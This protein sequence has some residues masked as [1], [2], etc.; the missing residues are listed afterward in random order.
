MLSGSGLVGI[1]QSPCHKIKQNG[2]MKLYSLHNLAGYTSLEP[3]PV[4][5][6]LSLAKRTW[7]K[8]GEENQEILRTIQRS[9]EKH[10]KKQLKQ[11]KASKQ[12]LHRALKSKTQNPNPSSKT[13]SVGWNAQTKS[14]SKWVSASPDL[15]ISQS[16]LL[17]PLMVILLIITTN[18]YPF[19]PPKSHWTSHLLFQCLCLNHPH[20][21]KL[22]PF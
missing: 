19:L 22:E 6:W 21:H 8:R 13:A 20:L 3:I 4:S 2:H 15:V 16:L 11:P 5:L 12:Q 17:P 7:T 1:S 18:P 14:L 9:K 10:Q